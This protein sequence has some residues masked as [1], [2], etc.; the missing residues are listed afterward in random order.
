MYL[1]CNTGII[2]HIVDYGIAARNESHDYCL[3]NKS[4]V[5]YSSLNSTLNTTLNKC[6]YNKTCMVTGLKNYVNSNNSTC[7]NEDANFHVQYMCG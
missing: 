2:A 5:C 6:L 4:G 1:S 3:N 7:K